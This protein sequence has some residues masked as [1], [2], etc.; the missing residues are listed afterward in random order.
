VA[1][2]HLAEADVNGLDP[3]ARE[4]RNA[5]FERVLREAAAQ[6]YPDIYRDAAR[7]LGFIADMDSEDRRR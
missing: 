4:H 1:S 7:L 2:F 3:A 6:G 5:E